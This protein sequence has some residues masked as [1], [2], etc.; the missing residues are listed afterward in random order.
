MSRI[1]SRSSGL[2][3]SW[4]FCPGSLLW[5]HPL[6]PTKIVSKTQTGSIPLILLFLEIIPWYWYRQNTGVSLYSQAA[7][8][9]ITSS[10][11]LFRDSSLATQCQAC[12]AFHSSLVS[13]E[14]A[15]PEWFLDHQVQ[16]PEWGTIL[17]S[18]GTHLCVLTLR[19][20]FLEVLTSVSWSLLITASSSVPNDLHG[21]SQKI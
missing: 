17:A 8:S 2:F 20:H 10:W 15:P 4:F 11:A 12:G 21:L 1:H 18:L 19:K 14:P 9:P 7:L 16:L 3:S 6:Q 5:L 13:S